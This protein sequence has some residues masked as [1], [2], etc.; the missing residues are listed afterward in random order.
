[1]QANSPPVTSNQTAPHSDLA[2]VVRKHLRT[3]Y[4][5]PYRAFSRDI[6]ETLAAEVTKRSLPLIL[7][8]GCGT[9][10]STLALAERHPGSFVVGI[11]KSL[12]RL[13]KAREK[14]TPPQNMHL[15]RADLIDIWRLAAQAG[16]QLQHHYLLYPNPWP[17][18]CRLK[19][20]WHAHPVFPDILKLGGTLHLR[21][22]WRLYLEE[23]AA[24]L[25]MA[26]G[27]Q[28][29]LHSVGQGGPLS[30]FERKYF[31]SGQQVFELEADLSL[32]GAGGG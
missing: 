25:E 13:A 15:V 1:M 16:W 5:R 30:A 24:A 22:N 4:R 18:K 19:R 9:G 23:F 2:A 11:D 28:V 31:A 20:R 27:L 17:K 32:A 14:G 10:D 3:Q 29:A 12:V 21:S 6:F 8:C 7:D 26:T